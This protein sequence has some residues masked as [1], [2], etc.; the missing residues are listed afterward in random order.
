MGEFIVNPRRAPRAPTRCRASVVCPHGPFEADTEDIGSMGCQVVSPH[1]VHKGD[2][3]RLLVTNEKV[4]EPLEVTGCVAWVSPHAPWRVGIAFEERSLAQSTRWF[5]SL[6]SAYPGMRGYRR[7]PDRIRTD[8]TV[9]LGA[10]PRFLVDF[11]TEEAIVLRAIGSGAQVDDLIARLRDRWSGA[12]RGLFSLIARQAVTLQRGQSV[13]P[14]SWKQI[15]TDIEASLAVELLGQA[16]SGIAAPIATR[17][18]P[19]PPPRAPPRPRRAAPAPPVPPRS[20]RAPPSPGAGWQ[21]G[22]A[23]DPTPVVELQ[24]DDGPPLEIAA[25]AHPRGPP[26]SVMR[27]LDRGS[28][29]GESSGRSRSEARAER[30]ASRETPRETPRDTPTPRDTATPRDT[31]R[32]RRSGEVQAAYDRALERVRA[33][34]KKGA[35]ALLRLAL[36]LA[37]GDREIADWL[38]NLEK[39]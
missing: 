1:V 29:W 33:G 36:S 2:V 35:V 28:D 15:L 7:V 19:P 14:E 34:N 21:A 8:A 27:G 6:I 31:P 11:T 37:P 23:Y 26:R 3:L 16:G 4:A 24:H 25:P 9:Y 32:P 5:D 20:G 22:Q 12:Q 18:P 30:A 13:H 10:P 38:A 17:T 39:A